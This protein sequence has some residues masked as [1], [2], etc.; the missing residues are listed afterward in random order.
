MAPDGNKLQVIYAQAKSKKDFQRVLASYKDA[1]KVDGLAA[2]A[3][4][5]N[6]RKQLSLITE[7][8]LIIHINIEDKGTADAREKA[9][10]IAHD[11]LKKI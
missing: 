4:W 6:K 10:N 1:V 9:T 7:K 3:V 8:N 2:E 11:I 5:S